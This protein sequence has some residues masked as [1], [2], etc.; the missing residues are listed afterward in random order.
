MKKLN[1]MMCAASCAAAVALASCSSGEGQWTVTGSVSGAEGSALV[2]EVPGRAGWYAVDSV[3]LPASGKFRMRHAAPAYPAIYRLRLGPDEIYLPADSTETIT[4]EADSATFA[5]GYA[6][7][8]SEQAQLMAN[9]D[10][11]VRE[12][13]PDI[14]SE[15]GSIILG[16]P[17]SQVAYYI[18]QKRVNG[19]PLFNP[20]D[21]MDLRFIGA[22]ANAYDNSRPDDPRA[23]Y[24]KRLFLQNR[25]RTSDAS[26]TQP[27]DTLYVSEMSYPE[28]TLPDNRGRQRSLSDAVGTNKV[29]VLNFVLYGAEVSPAL[30]VQLGELYEAYHSRGLE[31]YQIGV[32]PDQ[33]QWQQSADNMPWITVY[34]SPSAPAGNL[35]SYNVSGVPAVFIFADGELVERL[36]DLSS[37]K[38]AVAKRF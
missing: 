23:E 32:D 15:L 18:I 13:G 21:R 20:S 22:V 31:I 34:Q 19:R 11:I 12:Q 14:K 5:T 25:V 2:L 17:G 24:L 10:K 26:S 16:A 29:V 35:L 6:V 38:K 37:L 7:T 28:I 4:V 8:G 1:R 33:Y 9:V 27:V 3:V 30:N 36:T